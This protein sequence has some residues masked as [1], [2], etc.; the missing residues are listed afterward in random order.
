MEFNYNLITS[1]DALA[2]CCQHALAQPVIALD[3]EF[4]RTRTFYPALG[5]VQLYDGQQTSLID[6]LTITQWQPFIELLTAPNVMKLLH[7]GS[8][9][10]EIFWHEFGVVPAPFIDTQ[11]AASFSGYPLSTGYAKLVFDKLGI[12]LDKSET[13]TDWIARPLSQQQCYYAAADVYYLL[14]MA[15][16]LL[17]DVDTAD[18]LAAVKEESAALAEKRSQTQDVELAYL[19]IKNAWQLEG[20][21]L[22]ALQKLATWRVNYAKRKNLALNFVVREENLFAVA[23]KLPSDAAVLAELP[24]SANEIRFHGNQLLALV[25]QAKS[26]PVEDYPEP[27]DRLVDHRGYKQLFKL[28]KSELLALAQHYDISAELLASR[29]QINQLLKWYWSP[30]KEAEC[31]AAMPILLSGWRAKITQQKLDALLKEHA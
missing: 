24:L 16:Q 9:D 6:P 4:V 21:Q 19:D 14:P 22:V 17:A 13:C 23:Q 25:E 31:I 20:Q 28:I 15:T 10:L 2:Q 7:A 5:L 11:I 8:E 30:S 1:N 3:T 12:E 18:R 27:I 29:K 26:V